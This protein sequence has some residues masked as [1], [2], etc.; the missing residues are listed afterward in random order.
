MQPVGFSILLAEDHTLFRSMLAQLLHACY[1]NVRICEATN[2]NEALNF[3]RQEPFEVVIMD[4]NMP[5]MDGIDAISTIRAM[6]LPHQPK[7][8]VLSFHDSP[9]VVNNAITVGADGYLTK[10]IDSKVLIRAIEVIR[11]GEEYIHPEIKR[12]YLDLYKARQHPLDEVKRDLL[13]AQER[14]IL[15]FM[16]VGATNAE[17]SAKLNISDSTVGKHKTNIKNRIGTDSWIGFVKYALFYKIIS[18][19]EIFGL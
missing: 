1:P 13:T 4:I 7:I 9:I 6:E 12:A 5:E 16:C 19:E 14:K 10:D 11:Q 18:K 15:H 3:I 17:I 8:L 2:G